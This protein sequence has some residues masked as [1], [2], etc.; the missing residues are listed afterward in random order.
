MYTIRSITFNLNHEM[1]YLHFI[2]KGED[3]FIPSAFTKLEVFQYSPFVSMLYVSFWVFLEKDVQSVKVVDFQVHPTCRRIIIWNECI[4]IFFIESK[5]NF[6]KKNYMKDWQCSPIRLHDMSCGH[7]S[8]MD[9]KVH[10]HSFPPI[11]ENPNSIW[12]DFEG[13]CLP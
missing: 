6:S 9:F 1:N 3:S 10:H 8:Q 13:N 4:I 12:N 5:V 11:F 2:S 7:T